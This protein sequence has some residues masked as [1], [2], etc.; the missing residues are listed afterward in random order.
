[1]L[2]SFAVIDWYSVIVNSFWILGLAILLAA[3]SYHY[4][5]AQA[6]SRSLKEQLNQSSFPRFFWISFVFVGIGLAGT[7]Q[8]TWETVIW[9][10]FTLISLVNVVLFDRVSNETNH[11]G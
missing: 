11:N 4:W 2:Y 8:R 7:S 10:L 1:M 3:F 6:E 9:I 5:L